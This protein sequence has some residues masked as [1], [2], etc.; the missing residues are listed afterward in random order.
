MGCD[1]TATLDLIVNESTSSLTIVIYRDSYSWN[2][3]N[4]T[5]SGQYVYATVNTNGCDSIANLD[6]I[7]ILIRR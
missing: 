1:S 6:L 2:G 5:N 7:M 3:L 4:I